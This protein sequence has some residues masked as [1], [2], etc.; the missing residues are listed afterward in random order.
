MVADLRKLKPQIMFR[1]I[2][3]STDVSLCCFSEASHPTNR[4][5]DQTDSFTGV[6]SKGSIGEQGLFHMI[7]GTSQKQ[8]RVVTP[9][10]ITGDIKVTIKWW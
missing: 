7:D 4:D 10:A 8:Q 2:E 5:Y 6:L 3:N 9:H 1:K